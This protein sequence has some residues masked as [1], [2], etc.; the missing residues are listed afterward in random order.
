MFEEDT[1]LED[2]KRQSEI[3]KLKLQELIES[4]YNKSFVIDSRIKS[5]ESLER[6]KKLWK[7]KFGRDFSI[8]AFPDVI[9]YRISVETEEE[10]REI[11]KILNETIPP[12]G[13]IDYYKYPKE[14]GFRAYLYHYTGYGINSEIQIMTFKMKEWTNSTHKEHE[15]RKYGHL[16]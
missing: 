10:C 15:E 8:S 3:F 14:T 11:A 6:K 4:K 9:G 2:A 5:H 1:I 7:N 12:Q 16:K 13:I